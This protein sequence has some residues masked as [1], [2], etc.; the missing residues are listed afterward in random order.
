MRPQ[1]CH[2]TREDENILLLNDFRVMPRESYDHL[3]WPRLGEKQRKINFHYLITIKSAAFVWLSK[4]ES[5]KMVMKRPDKDGRRAAKKGH[6]LK[7]EEFHCLWVIYWMFCLTARC[8]FNG[9]RWTI[10]AA[11]GRE[12]LVL[13]EKKRQRSTNKK[14]WNL[15]WLLKLALVSCSCFCFSKTCH[16]VV[17]VVWNIIAREEEK[18]LSHVTEWRSQGDMEPKA[19]E[20]YRQFSVD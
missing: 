9:D 11:K 16:V 20:I 4:G 12:E 10:N 13:R 1:N 7:S 5:N 2:K 18:I 14:K 15:M 17:V 6:Q 19:D 8:P 3:K